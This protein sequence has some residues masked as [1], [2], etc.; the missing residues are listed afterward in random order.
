VFSNR[1][2]RHSLAIARNGAC[3][4]SAPNVSAA[5]ITRD[6]ASNSQGRYSRESR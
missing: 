1:A 5:Q 3:T 2:A 6:L 4:G